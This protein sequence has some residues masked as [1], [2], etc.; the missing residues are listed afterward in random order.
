MGVGAG[1]GG[2]GHL[3]GAAGVDAD[4]EEYGGYVGVTTL[5]SVGDDTSRLKNCCRNSAEHR[6]HHLRQ[7]IS[8]RCGPPCP[9]EAR[10]LVLVVLSGRRDRTDDL[11]GRGRPA[12]GRALRRRPG[13][14]RRAR[15]RTRHPRQ[16]LD[17]ERLRGLRPRCRSG[18][19]PGRLPAW[20]RPGDQDWPGTTVVGHG[21]AVRASPSPGTTRPVRR[22]VD[23][24]RRQPVLLA[25]GSSA[26]PRGSSRSAPAHRSRRHSDTFGAEAGD[27]RARRP[28]PTRQP[29][30]GERASTPSAPMRSGRA[31][32]TVLTP[33]SAST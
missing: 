15:R 7:R 4:V 27:V 8:G 10:W 9:Q 12:T 1:F 14:R 20:P 18:P 26:R 30:M 33:C 32:K 11:L 23:Q 2:S 19:T 3:G 5:T 25:A 21:A 16:R 22:Q 29:S 24:P 13:V 28:S 17:R 6:S 31:T